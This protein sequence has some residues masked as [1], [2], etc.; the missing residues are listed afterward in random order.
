MKNRLFALG[1]IDAILFRIIYRKIR[2]K[3]D[4]TGCY[5]S[6]GKSLDDLEMKIFGPV[7]TSRY[8]KCIDFACYFSAKKYINPDPR[9]ESPRFVFMIGSWILLRWYEFRYRNLLPVYNTYILLRKKIPR[10][11]IDKQIFF[12]GNSVFKMGSVFGALVWRWKIQ[13]PWSYI[14]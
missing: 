6:L 12:N 4:P 11:I 1:H 8:V 14:F 7:L 2:K 5:K 9:R 10:L 13:M 3:K